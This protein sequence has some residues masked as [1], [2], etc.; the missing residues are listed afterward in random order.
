MR[1]LPASLIAAIAA[2]CLTTATAQAQKKPKKVDCHKDLE[3]A[4]QLIDAR[5]SFKI[6]KPG[7]VEIY[8]EYRRLAPAARQATAPEACAEVL[9][10]FMATLR[11]G[12]SSLRYFPGVV[13]SRP[14]I[15]IRSQRERL[16]RIAGQKPK[17][18]AYVFSRDSTDESL[19]E[20]RPGSQVL[21]VDSVPVDSLYDW[22]ADRVS[23]STSQWVDYMCDRRLLAGPP[24]SEVELRLRQPGGVKTLV[25]QRP[26]YPTEEES[27]QAEREAEIYRDTVNIAP[28]KRLEGG[29]GYVKYATFS[30]GSMEETLEPFDEAIDSLLDAPGL[31]ID[32]R[33]NGGGIVGAMTGAAGR[34]VTER[35]PVEYY[36]I[37]K[38]G[39][40]DVI[41]VWDPYTGSPTVR[42]SWMARPRGKTYIGPLV[43]LIDR[44]CFSACEGFAAGLQAIDRALVVG[45]SASGG[46]SGAV[47]GLKLPSGAIISF[48]WTVGWRPDGQQVEGNGVYPDVIVRER[49]PDWAAGRDRMLERAIK[50][51]ETGEA[52]ALKLAEGG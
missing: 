40:Q 36:Q 34:F 46:G 6:F 47:S 42:P 4:A 39:Q 43:I 2:T 5:W 37:R 9:E 3:K 14:R 12:H 13:S 18:R 16:S 23:G 29:W 48:S 20:I 51:L 26:G 1:C 45:S 7:V 35:F 17:I 30:F 27:K 19:K 31:I 25:V 8:A 44:R 28:W 49:P 41:E 33:G 50:A 11:D 24:G 15:E 38:P 52:K 10:R 32:L 22:M 21:A